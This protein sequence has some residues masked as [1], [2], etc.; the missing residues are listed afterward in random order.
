[1]SNL[2]DG[3]AAP[4]F[5]PLRISGN[6]SLADL[7]ALGASEGMAKTAEQAPRGSAVGWGIPFEIGEQVI[8]LTGESFRTAVEPVRAGWL[9][10][11]HTTDVMPPVRNEDGFVS[12]ARGMVPL[13]QHLA[14]Y[15]IEYADGSEVCAEVRQ[16]HQVDA[17]THSWGEQPF[18]SVWM[19]KPQPL[20]SGLSDKQPLGDW[21]FLQTRAGGGDGAAWMNYLWAWQNPH[22]EKE[23]TAL[24]FEPT[25]DALLVVSAV[26]AGTVSDQPLRWQRRRKALLRLPEGTAFQPGV[27][28]EGLLAQIRLDLGQVISAQPRLVY[29]DADWES[30][31][32]NQV[33]QVSPNEILVEYTAH[34]DACFHLWDG[35]VLPL[36]GISTTVRQLQPPELRPSDAGIIVPVA[37]S[38]QRV[39][40]RIAEKGSRR[41]V[42]VKL[43][44]H[45][46]AGEYLA[47]VDRHRIINP[48]WYEDYSVDF[49]HRWAHSTSYVYG[50]TD[51][52]LPLGKVYVEVSKGFEIRPVRKVID[53]GGDTTEVVIEVE[54]V[55]PWR[56]RGWVTA[57][58]HVHFLS[59]G[60]AMLEGAGEGVNIVNLLASQWGELMT[61][62]GDFDGRTTYG[63]GAEAG[64]D[65]DGEYLV[66]VGTENRQHVLGHISLL[67]YRGRIIA[68]MTTGG[69]DESAIGDPVEVL[70][71]E[72]ARQCHKQGGVVVLPHFPEPRAEHAASIISGDID[73]LEMTSWGDLYS[74]INPYSLSDWYRYLNCGYKVAAVGGTDKMSAD[75]AVGTVRTYARIP[76]YQPF[77]YEAWMEAVRRAETFVT[78]G[79]LLE[80]NVDGKPMGS[81]FGMSASRGT[82]DITWQVSSV[83]IPVSEVQ[84]VVNGE[85]RECED[86]APEG[87][88]GS[89]RVRVDKSCWLALLVRG[90]YA[91]QPSIIAAHSSPVM[92]DVAGSPM[93]PAADALT[94]LEQIEG[95]LAFFDTI[96]TRAE[97][98]AYKRMRLVLETAHRELHNRMHQEGHFHEHTPPTDHPEHHG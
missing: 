22:P 65:G 33:P 24:R 67:G 95:A 80:F 12:P 30:S 1:M 52:D 60:S 20:R 35:Q 68:P 2:M 57:D 28:D 49:M 26:S 61:N 8:V 41:P 43:H 97:D 3:P 96:G 47:P 21:G 86:L 50:E 58:T 77:T 87:G 11:M 82:V 63:A 98:V 46:E 29:L 25:G 51:V 88:T 13:N 89:W 45:G 73:A 81:R 79:P 66:R 53:V 19:H 64:P 37:P 85:I 72:W 44:L 32:N 23:I 55:L 74:G 93:L 17:Y 59:P 4:C 15:V 90:H 42:S 84:L 78:Y 94:I 7:P 18:Q 6:H 56:E 71:T 83:T 70:L 69:P 36:A 91:D 62:V 76:A 16:R 9:V 5:A 27:D 31:Y 75:T 40:L 92:I 10:F 34:P 38:H 48:A 39:T 54:K 14:D